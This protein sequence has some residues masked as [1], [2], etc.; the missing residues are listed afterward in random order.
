[1]K[2]RFITKSAGPE[3]VI[4][5]GHVLEVDDRE[6]ALLV[7]KR[8]AEYVDKPQDAPAH[9][10]QPGKEAAPDE[11]RRAE[12]PDKKAVGAAK[13]TAKKGRRAKQE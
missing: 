2:V 13:G 5:P 4:L 7:E 10:K 3:G 11:G 9:A 8:Y 6:A 12:A 1:M